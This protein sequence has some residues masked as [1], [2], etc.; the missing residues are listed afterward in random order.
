MPILCDSYQM[1]AKKQGIYTEVDHIFFFVEQFSSSAKKND[2]K[3]KFK[4]KN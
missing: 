4:K 1:N 2:Q 3:S